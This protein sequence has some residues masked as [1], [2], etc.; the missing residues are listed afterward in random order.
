MDEGLK[1]MVDVLIGT[2][3]KAKQD[4]ELTIKVSDDKTAIHH[5][6]NT[7]QTIEKMIAGVNEEL[8]LLKNKNS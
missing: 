6:P 2:L 7:V 4:I 3:E 5:L 1:L 8:E